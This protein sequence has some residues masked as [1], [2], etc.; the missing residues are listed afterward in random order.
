MILSQTT[1]DE[2]G[3]ILLADP[4]RVAAA[5]ERLVDLAVAWESPSGLRPL[6]GVADAIRGSGSGVHPLSM[7]RL[8]VAAATVVLDEISP[9]AR[10]LLDHLDGAG[11]E[12]RTDS[13]RRAIPPEDATTPV[14][15]A[16][17]RGLLVPR[18]QRHGL[19]PR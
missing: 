10:G 3:S 12:G 5:T 1:R 14:E 16:L 8:D 15:E 2:I 18:E 13:A 17:S 4:A 6:T 7:G 11:G 9:A 19:S